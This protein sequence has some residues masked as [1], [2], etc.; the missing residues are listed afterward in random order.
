MSAERPWHSDENLEQYE[1]LFPVIPDYTA[2]YTIGG[3]VGPRI[4]LPNKNSLRLRKG[5]LAALI[6]YQAGLSLSYAEKRYA[7]EPTESRWLGL[8]DRI[9]K[10]YDFGRSRLGYYVSFGLDLPKKEGT[11]QD[12][13]MQFF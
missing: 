5:I 11:F 9:D 1:T 12:L 6:A 2:H 10:I 3:R 7:A 4:G 8:T 13:S